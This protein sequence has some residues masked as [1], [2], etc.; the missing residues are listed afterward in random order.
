MY[1]EKKLEWVLFDNLFLLFYRNIFPDNVVEATFRQSQ[2][3]YTHEKV[4]QVLVVDNATQRNISTNQNEH[5]HAQKV[6]KSV[7]KTDG[8]NI[9]GI[10][11]KCSWFKTFYK[12]IEYLLCFDTN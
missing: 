6:V 4:E 9:L 7:G 10:V 3:K 5:P 11:F 2:T 12:Q 1:L 8:P